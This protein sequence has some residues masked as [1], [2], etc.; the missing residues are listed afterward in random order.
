[1]LMSSHILTEIAQ[2]V[3]R[4]AILLRGRLLTVRSMEETPDLEELFL[5]LA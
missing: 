3:D 4:V 5:S 2:I 1:V